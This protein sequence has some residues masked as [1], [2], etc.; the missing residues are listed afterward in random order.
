MSSMMNLSIPY[1]G[2]KAAMSDLELKA[3]AELIDGYFEEFGE[4]YEFR[5][6]TMVLDAQ[7]TEWRDGAAKQGSWA[8]FGML[9][10]GEPQLLMRFSLPNGK[11]ATSFMNSDV[12][13]EEA[14]DSL[15]EGRRLFANHENVYIDGDIYAVSGTDQFYEAGRLMVVNATY[16]RFLA[17]YADN[18]MTSDYRAEHDYLFIAL[19]RALAMLFPNDP[20]LQRGYDWMRISCPV[21]N[22]VADRIARIMDETYDEQQ[23]TRG[24][25]LRELL[26]RR[27]A[28]NGPSIATFG[29]TS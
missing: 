25:A 8:S 1:H 21:P 3:L 22:A 24:S 29:K 4:I 15:V 19:A 27:K 6:G 9:K 17:G 7:P 18:F 2:E 28:A 20:M 5:R 14:I 10:F 11:E 16:G 26:D 23:K 12:M 13:A